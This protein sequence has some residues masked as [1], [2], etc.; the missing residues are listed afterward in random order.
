[1][2]VGV[3]TMVFRSATNCSALQAVLFGGSKG[4]NGFVFWLFI[5]GVVCLSGSAAWSALSVCLVVVLF[6]RRYL[7]V[8]VS[9][10]CWCCLVDAVCHM[11][12]CMVP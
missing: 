7:S 10:W 1:M 8:C 2:Q 6:G 4:A 5:G 11:A 9:L 3:V 12:G